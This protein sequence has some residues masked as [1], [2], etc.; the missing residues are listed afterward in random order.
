MD[1]R[2]GEKLKSCSLAC[3]WTRGELVWPGDKPNEEV[4]LERLG[5]GGNSLWCIAIV[6]IFMGL[7]GTKGLR[8]L[9]GFK[10]NV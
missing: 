7:G 3:H 2:M 8:G 6:V 9:G 1:K 4:F 10:V 5:V